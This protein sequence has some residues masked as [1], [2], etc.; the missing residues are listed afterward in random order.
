MLIWS[1]DDENVLTVKIDDEVI[2]GKYILTDLK[3]IWVEDLL[4]KHPDAQ[5]FLEK[6]DIVCIKCGEPVWGT[7]EE[8]IASKKGKKEVEKL[9]KELADYIE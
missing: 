4:E 2:M 9:I 6:N 8:L 3:K 7:I 1:D 5:D